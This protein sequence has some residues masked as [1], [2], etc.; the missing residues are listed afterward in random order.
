MPA[1]DTYHDVVRNALVKD[2][3][4]I[5]NDPLILRVGSKDLYVDLGAERLLAAEKGQERIAVEI[6]SF[7]GRSEIDDLEKALGQFVL[8]HDI[9]AEN[10]PC[11][12]L[13]LAVPA[14]VLRDLFQEAVGQLLLRNNRLRLV[15][16]DPAL[17]VILQ[18]IP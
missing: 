17:E 15:V 14:D 11:R 6:K 3:W 8:Y 7:V 16:F 13:Y 4:T 5:T 9:L 2:A 18:W 12:I 10:D 1:R